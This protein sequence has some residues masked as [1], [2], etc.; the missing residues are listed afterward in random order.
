MRRVVVPIAVQTTTIVKFVVSLTPD[1]NV[2][3]STASPSVT[4]NRSVKPSSIV[5]TASAEAT[6]HE[7][8]KPTEPEEPVESGTVPFSTH[9]K[10]NVSRSQHQY[11]VP[12]PVLAQQ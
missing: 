4:D 10:L 3:I 7:I 9:T 5:S 12:P 1:V 6:S 2:K 11:K 8:A